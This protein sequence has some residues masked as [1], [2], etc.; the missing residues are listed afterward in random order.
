MINSGKVINEALMLLKKASDKTRA[1][2]SDWYFPTSMEVLGVK[3]ADLKF[4]TRTIKDLI[5]KADDFEK[6]RLCNEMAISGNLEIQQLAFGILNRNFKL[7]AK[8][9]HNDIGILGSYMDNW[10]STD[11][12]AT[13]VAGPAWRLGVLDDTQVCNWAVS[14]DLWWR[15]IALVCTVSLNL[16]SQ[17]GEGDID[18]TLMICELLIDDREDMLIKAMSWALREL[19]K[20]YPE[21]VRKFLNQYDERLASRVRREVNTKLK[22]G[23]KNG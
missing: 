8:L 11:S 16:K 3:S 2:L 19:S 13:Q 15:R 18:R 6:I 12:F 7:I 1:G 9:N 17:K 14:P 10:V 23:K 22:T 5:K 21:E 4:I 20:R